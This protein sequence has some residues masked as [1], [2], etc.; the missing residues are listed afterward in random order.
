[1]QTRGKS[2]R[3]KNRWNCTNGQADEEVPAEMYSDCS[4]PQVQNWSGFH[5][6]Q[7]SRRLVQ[8]GLGCR[9][10]EGWWGNC[11]ARGSSKDGFRGRQLSPVFCIAVKVNYKVIFV[12]IYFEIQNNQKHV[13]HFFR[14]SL[15]KTPVLFIWRT[16]ISLRAFLYQRWSDV[17]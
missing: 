3:R 5:V 6:S 16:Y 13:P 12:V 14:M 9:E 1:M 17:V 8:V 11:S 10:E 2:A 4:T 15:V 7:T